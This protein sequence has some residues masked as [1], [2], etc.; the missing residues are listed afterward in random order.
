MKYYK[1]IT[2]RNNMFLYYA[3][4]FFLICFIVI[5]IYFN[6]AYLKN[7]YKIDFFEEK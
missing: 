7:K 6:K 4:S 1:K 3:L 2:H 5:V